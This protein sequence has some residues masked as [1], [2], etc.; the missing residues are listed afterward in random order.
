VS[1]VGEQG[2][3]TNEASTLSVMPQERVFMAETPSDSTCRRRPALFAI[4]S[5]ADNGA[6]EKLGGCL[7]ATPENLLTQSVMHKKGKQND[8]WERDS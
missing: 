3:H 4:Q 1:R 7:T 6:N 5:R 2:R 8:Y